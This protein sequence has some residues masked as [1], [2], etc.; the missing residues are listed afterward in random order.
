MC[1]PRY[2]RNTDDRT[3]GTGPVFEL[4]ESKERGCMQ[5][6]AILNCPLNFYRLDG[7]QILPS[8]PFPGSKQDRALSGKPFIVL[9]GVITSVSH[10][11][12]F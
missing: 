1:F 11:E 9:K 7:D 12:V 8:N 10:S 6:H 3:Q 4:A 2:S 5:S